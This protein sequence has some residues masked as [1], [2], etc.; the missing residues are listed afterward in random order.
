MTADVWES[1]A[2]A[3]HDCMAH[4][5]A[6]SVPPLGYLWVCSVCGETLEREEHPWS[7]AELANLARLEAARREAE[8]IDR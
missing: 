3:P 1:T 2:P 6:E 8:M 4:A 7:D 5:T